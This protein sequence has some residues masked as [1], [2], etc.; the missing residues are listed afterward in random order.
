MNSAKPSVRST[1]PPSDGDLLAGYPEG[2]PKFMDIRPDQTAASILTNT[3]IQRI[4]K[5]I[6]VL[7]FVL[8]VSLDFPAQN[9]PSGITKEEVIERSWKEMFGAL[10]N[11]DLKSIYVE[12]F[13]HGNTIPNKITIQRPN[14]FR[15]EVPS[16]VLV[17]DGNRAAWVKRYPDQQG[18]PRNP[19]I[20]NPA[21][22]RHFEVDIALIFPAF[23]DHK[24]EYRG[25]KTLDGKQYYEIF[26]ILPMGASLS[27]FIDPKDFLI[28]RRMVHW[29]GKPGDAGWENMIDNYIDYSGIR[30]PEGY[31]HMG[32]KGREKG[33]YKN[34]RMNINPGE[35]VFFIPGDIK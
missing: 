15:N 1:F 9:K 14:K 6:L 27:Y 29:E 26:V 18:N 3:K 13:F 7:F 24:S 35:Q 4:L 31:S 16:G 32:Q 34:F 23:F 19:K 17:F 10:K 8:S 21:Y 33:F 11:E 30:F 22:C 20:I 28:K 2:C 12:G 5:I 25:I